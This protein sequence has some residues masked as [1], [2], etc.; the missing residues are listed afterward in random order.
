MAKQYRS[1]EESREF[2]QA[3]NLKGYEHWRE[4]LTTHKLPLDMPKTVDWYY[5]K[6]GT[7]V[8][9]VD[10]LGTKNK[11][12]SKSNYFT[13]KQCKVFLRK[14]RFLTP[15][16]FF[17]HWKHNKKPKELPANPRFF[18]IYS[19][20]SW[21]DLF[22]NRAEL[23][24]ARKIETRERNKILKIDKQREKEIEFADIKN[25]DIS[26]FSMGNFHIDNKKLIIKTK[27]HIPLYL[28]YW[29][30]LNPLT[31]TYI[32]YYNDYPLEPNDALYVI[33][34]NKLTIR[35]GEQAII[36]KYTEAYISYFA[37][38]KIKGKVMILNSNKK[39]RGIELLSKVL[40]KYIGFVSY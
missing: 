7:W 30:L 1:Y 22:S 25:I 8:D 31:N 36:N 3:L 13:Y 21:N 27:P 2:A 19:F 34:T 17:E 10:F 24:K 20:I 23:L 32:V 15:K 6:H 38:K 5:K 18:Y 40:G 11:T 14:Y 35:K 37:K 16:S 33:N 9:W 12:R 4:Y 29:L 26:K 28:D 39:V